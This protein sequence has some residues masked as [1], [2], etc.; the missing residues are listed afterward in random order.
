MTGV[1][2]GSWDGEVLPAIAPVGD[3][4]V[5][6]KG[7]SSLWMSTNVGYLLRSMG[8]NQVVM[9]GALTD[10]CVESAIRDACDDSEPQP[11]PD[12]SRKCATSSPADT[13]RA[14]G[15]WLALLSEREATKTNTLCCCVAR[16]LGDAG[17][18][19]LRDLLEGAARDI[20]QRDQGLL[21]AAN[22]R[23][24]AARGAASR[25]SLRRQQTQKRH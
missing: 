16:L 1:P 18:G 23:R 4:I 22:H 12:P 19:R 25:I 5:L 7:S 6:P 17:N 3:E 21:Q 20:D 2:K 15:L 13:K 14:L 8:M 24:A 10:Q 11:P 9:V